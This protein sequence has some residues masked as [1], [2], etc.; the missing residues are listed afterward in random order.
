L[1][2]LQRDILADAQ[3]NPLSPFGKLQAVPVPPML[4]T[5]NLLL[6]SPAGD[7]LVLTHEDLIYSCREPKSLDTVIAHAATAGAALTGYLAAR[8]ITKITRVGLVVRTLKGAELTE[9]ASA[10]SN[11]LLPGNTGPLKAFLSQET[12]EITRS[13]SHY[14]NAIYL[15]DINQD[16]GI[17]VSSL[18]H[19]RYFTPALETL[20]SAAFGD[21]LATTESFFR[22]QTNTP[23]DLA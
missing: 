9:V 12:A 23:Y 5:T 19:Q 20:D 16:M 14:D 21:F 1:R 15:I 10:A 8:S 22:T 11:V 7:T 13:S 18:D 2:E 17:Y 6:A 4:D 3:T